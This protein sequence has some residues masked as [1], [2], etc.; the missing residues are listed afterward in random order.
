MIKTKKNITINLLIILIIL[1]INLIS[2]S[3]CQTIVYADMNGSGETCSEDSPCDLLTAVSNLN[4]NDVLYINDGNYTLNNTLEINVANITVK[5][6]SQR[7][8]WHFF[9]LKFI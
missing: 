8:F 3:H 2:V 9:F 1:I 6:Q 5:G 4:N 7:L